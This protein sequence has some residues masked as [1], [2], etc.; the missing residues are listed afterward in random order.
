MKYVFLAAFLA[1]SL[2]AQQ[3]TPETADSGPRVNASAP[4]TV[5]TVEAAPIAADPTTAE[6]KAKDTKVNPSLR[7][8]GGDLVDIKVYGVPELS[9]TVR[10]SSNG[11]L[12]LPLIGAVHVASLTAEQAEKAIE[13]KL[14]DGNF[15]RDPHVNVF[16]KEFS[17]QGISVMG[18]VLKPGIYP[19]LGAHRLFDA[20]SAA[21]GL[22]PKAGRV[23][24]IT[25]RDNP[26]EPVIVTMDADPVK[27]SGS[28]VEVQPG[29][30]IVVSKA[31]VIYVVGDVS[32]P[33]GFVMENNESLTVLQALALAQ[34]NNPT[35][36]LNN[37]KVI[38]KTPKGLTE[39]PVPLKNI[40][41]NKGADIALQGDDILFVPASEGKRAVRRTLEAVVQMATGMAV[42]RR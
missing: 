19:L 24:A 16:V 12:S 30:T 40:L 29:D 11:E 18:E 10:V 42:Y 20:I 5:G 27:A 25:H 32:K 38:R 4:Q 41:Q 37:A 6:S 26:A 33:G 17:T 15:L 13:R 35:A 9:D 22:T 21:S 39:I 8:S 14:I 28:N 7:L 3:T 1:S 23:I 2:Y 36:S 31:G 34:G